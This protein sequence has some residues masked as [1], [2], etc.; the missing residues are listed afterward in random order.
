[1]NIMF[2]RTF[3]CFAFFL[4]S[5]SLPF[6]AEY[7]GQNIDGQVYDAT[8]FSYATGQYYNASGE[9]DGDEAIIFFANGGSIKVTLDDEEID[10]PQSISAFDYNKGAYWD[11]DVDGLD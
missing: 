11:L 2:R 6:A 8:V 10:D 1:M 4:S 9:F 3:L 7:Q 5:T